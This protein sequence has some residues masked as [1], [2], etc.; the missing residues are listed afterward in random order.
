M[1]AYIEAYERAYRQNALIELGETRRLYFPSSG[2]YGD[3]RASG[4]TGHRALR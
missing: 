1:L 2:V 4:P 3:Q